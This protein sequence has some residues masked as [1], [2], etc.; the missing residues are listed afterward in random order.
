M[1]SRGALHFHVLLR[2]PAKRGGALSVK[3]LRRLAIQYGFGHSVDLA[4]V[5]DHRAA[6]Y[7]AKYV[8]K[9]CADRSG[10]PWVHHRTGEVSNGHGRYRCWTAS[11]H[12]GT[13]MMQV[14]AQQAAW[15]AAQAEAAPPAE[16][17]PPGPLDPSS[18]SYAVELLIRELGGR[19]WHG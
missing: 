12:W 2:M 18:Q 7:V 5:Q 15:W 16:P 9:A 8:V 6:G 17:A 10:M 11:R 3:Q 1:Q 4:V 14:R 13:T 19:L